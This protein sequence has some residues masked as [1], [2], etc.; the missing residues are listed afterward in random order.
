MA[1]DFSGLFGP[2]AAQ[3]QQGGQ[4][5]AREQEQPAQEPPEA[6]QE[7]QAQQQRSFSLDRAAEER[8][9]VSEAYKRQAEAIRKS[10]RL[11]TEITKGIK[12][13]EP[14]QLLF[15]KALECVSVA[16]GDTV[17][18][19]Q[20]RESYIAIYGI[21][22]QQPEAAAVEL[23]EVQKRLERLQETYKEEWPT[24]GDKERIGAAI[25]AHRERERQLAAI[26]DA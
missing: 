8:R 21:G 26:V 3:G 4:R 6:S 15:L 14:V 13:G 18:L 25:R 10:E 5:E 17:F 20:N 23:A 1:L 24:A 7:A 19:D 22:L 9:R 16:T 11:R 2:T 12:R